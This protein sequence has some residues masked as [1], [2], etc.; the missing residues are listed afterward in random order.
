MAP[1]LDQ[2]GG[3]AAGVGHRPLLRKERAEPQPGQTLYN[4]CHISHHSAVYWHHDLGTGFRERSSEGLEA[5]FVFQ[6]RAR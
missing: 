4:L 1:G 6:E 2:A 5:L 3:L